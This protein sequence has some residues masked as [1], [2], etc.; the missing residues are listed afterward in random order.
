MTL[1]RK[2]LISISGLVIYFMLCIL[3]GG[4][5]SM[6]LKEGD[7]AP[8]FKAVSS[9]TKEVSLKDYKGKSRI[10]LYFYPKDDTPGCTV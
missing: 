2:R 3:K 7:K 10:V 4:E 9:E 6:A 8:D 1:G 5:A